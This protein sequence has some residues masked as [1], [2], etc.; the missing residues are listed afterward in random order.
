VVGIESL[1]VPGITDPGAVGEVIIPV[2]VPLLPGVLCPWVPPVYTSPV[3][4]DVPPAPDAPPAPDELL[5]ARA[6]MEVAAS[7]APAAIRDSA[8]DAMN[9][10]FIDVS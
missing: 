8:L 1:A 6:P 3:V 5:C 4:L 9:Y 10:T 7:N 2:L